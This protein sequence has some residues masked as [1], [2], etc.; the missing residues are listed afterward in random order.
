MI[1]I[2]EVDID[3]QSCGDKVLVGRI[4]VLKITRPSTWLLQP[5]GCY[6]RY[7]SGAEDPPHGTILTMGRCCAESDMWVNPRE[8][9]RLPMACS[10][11]GWV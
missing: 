11:S 5:V 4:V 2:L 10:C 7:V 9:A 8:L 3:K 6:V 1:S